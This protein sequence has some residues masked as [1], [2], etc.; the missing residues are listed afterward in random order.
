M[1][2]EQGTSTPGASVALHVQLRETITLRNKILK[3]ACLA[4]FFR[5]V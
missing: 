2:I 4:N 3:K 1:L 5:C